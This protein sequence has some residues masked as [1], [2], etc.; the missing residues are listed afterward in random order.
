MWL[1]HMGLAG[2]EVDESNFED[3]SLK[4]ASPASGSCLSRGRDWLS[5]LVMISGERERGGVSAARVSDLEGELR[6]E[7]RDDRRAEVETDTERKL[8]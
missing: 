1:S 2:S 5:R 4:M 6:K 3:S 7:P 8:P